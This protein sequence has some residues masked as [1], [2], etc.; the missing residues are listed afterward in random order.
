VREN[1][2]SKVWGNE[3]QSR[4]H[5]ATSEDVQEDKYSLR[6]I[7]KKA[8]SP[9]FNH[10]SHSNGQEKSKKGDP[11]NE[12]ISGDVYENKWP[13]KLHIGESEDVDENKH[14]TAFSQICLRK[15]GWLA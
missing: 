14:V 10:S 6:S 1:T 13:R 15:E 11:K 4:K 12:G 8:I 9:E 2:Q 7:L 3:R 5:T